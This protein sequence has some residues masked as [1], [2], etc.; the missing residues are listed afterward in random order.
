MRVAFFKEQVGLSAS[1]YRAKF[2]PP[3]SNQMQP[4]A[5]IVLPG[6]L[7]NNVDLLI[8]VKDVVQRL[9]IGCPCVG[10][11]QE[12]AAFRPFIPRVD[13]QHFWSC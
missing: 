9:Q 7:Q 4:I 11:G 8:P 12:I 10:I 5:E 3:S 1:S 13:C 6:S 2:L